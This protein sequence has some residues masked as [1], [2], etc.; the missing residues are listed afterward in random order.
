MYKAIGRSIINYA[1]PVWSPYLLGHQLGCTYLESKLLDTNYSNI[2]YAQNEVCLQMS[3]N[4]PYR[5]PALW[6]QNAEDKGTLRAT[7]GKKMSKT[8]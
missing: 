4:V 1:A 2:Q 3:Y 8:R 7:D 6:G 5:P